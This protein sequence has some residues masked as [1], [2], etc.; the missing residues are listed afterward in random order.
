[1][2]RLIYKELIAHGH[3]TVLTAI[4]LWNRLCSMAGRELKLD[5]AYYFIEPIEGHEEKKEEVFKFYVTGRSK[6][7]ITVAFVD[8]RREEDG[9]LTEDVFFFERIELTSYRSKSSLKLDIYRMEEGCSAYRALVEILKGAG[10]EQ[11]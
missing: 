7:M 4:M 2:N 9:C 3:G 8:P 10:D 11:V 5:S 6:E 1:M